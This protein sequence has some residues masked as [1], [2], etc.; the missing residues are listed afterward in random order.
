MANAYIAIL[1]GTKSSSKSF[2]RDARARNPATSC[3]FVIPRKF[4]NKLAPA[5]WQTRYNFEE[6]ESWNKT[7]DEHMF[8]SPAALSVPCK[9]EIVVLVGKC[10]KE[11]ADHDNEERSRPTVVTYDDKALIDR[12]KSSYATDRQLYN[13]YQEEVASN[14]RTHSHRRAVFGGFLWRTESG[15]LQLCVPQDNDLRETIIREFH[16]SNHAGHQSYKRTL[17][18][19][20]RRFWWNG[21]FKDVKDF[22]DGCHTCQMSNV[23]TAKPNGTLNPLSI[24]KRKWELLRWTL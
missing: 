2:S 6:Y 16:E 23:S 14:P 8:R 4:V 22:C 20:R 15:R 5:S 12:L 1:H 19:I 9:H 18:K 21:M 13:E 24:P 10:N 7:R 17:E 3:V 11:L